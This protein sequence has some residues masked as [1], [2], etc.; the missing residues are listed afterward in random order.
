MK[1]GIKAPRTM[2]AARSSLEGDDA[3]VR[4]ALADAI[5]R[6]QLA[7]V[8]AERL[9]HRLVADSD[10]LAKPGHHALGDQKQERRDE[11][12]RERGRSDAE[13]GDDHVAG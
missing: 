4:A 2:R 3:A 8:S 13:H 1:T 10:R 9:A 12:V 5:A 7:L 11:Q 6:A